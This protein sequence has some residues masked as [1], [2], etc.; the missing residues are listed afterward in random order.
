MDGSLFFFSFLLTHVETVSEAT[1]GS[2]NLHILEKKLV[3]SGEHFP[4]TCSPWSERGGLQAPL[5]FAEENPSSI[6]KKIIT[7]RV[8]NCLGLEKIQ[9]NDS[10]QIQHWITLQQ[11]RGR[12][13]RVNAFPCR[14]RFPGMQ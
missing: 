12:L 2:W 5:S 14:D 4:P 7:A 9:K 8:D 10:V 13:R 6:Q 11:F 1:G 3:L